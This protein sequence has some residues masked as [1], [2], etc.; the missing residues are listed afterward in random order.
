MSQVFH[1]FTNDLLGTRICVEIIKPGKTWMGRGSNSRNG[2]C[3]RSL[4]NCPYRF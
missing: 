3:E 2:T 4:H 1:G